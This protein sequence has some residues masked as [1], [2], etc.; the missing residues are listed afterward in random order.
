M[1]EVYGATHE[2]DL[3]GNEPQTP[4][5]TN[6]KRSRRSPTTTPKRTHLWGCGVVP[7]TLQVMLAAELSVSM[8]Q[9][10]SVAQIQDK[11]QPAGNAAFL[12][13]SLHYDVM[14]EYCSAKKGYQRESLMSTDVRDDKRNDCSDV[15]DVK[16]EHDLKDQSDDETSYERRKKRS[17]V[18]KPKS[19]SEA[20][21]AGFLALK[22]GLIHL[23]TSLASAPTARLVPTTGATMDDV[24]LAIQ[25]QSAMMAQLLAHLVAQKEI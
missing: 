4:Q 18:V 16:D 7:F 13:L 9:D 12:P 2:T 8:E 25:G 20:L 11:S 19:H 1:N 24:L 14:L 15:I 17:K 3:P 23:G 21:E 10:D 6:S 5:P 22:D